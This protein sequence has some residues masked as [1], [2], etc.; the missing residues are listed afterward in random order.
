MVQLSLP[1]TRIFPHTLWI[2]PSSLESSPDV[3]PAF[4]TTFF[5]PYMQLVGP[6]YWCRCWGTAKIWKS[7]GDAKHTSMGENIH[8]LTQEISMQLLHVHVHTDREKTSY[9]CM[10]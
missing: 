1:H 10:M 3:I 9:R 8:V 7:V 5:D 6:L 2:C 4:K